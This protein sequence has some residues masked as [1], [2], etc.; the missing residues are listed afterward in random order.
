MLMQGRD[1]GRPR[2][3]KRIIPCRRVAGQRRACNR[4]RLQ[5][6]RQQCILDGR[7]QMAEFNFVLLGIVCRLTSFVTW[8]SEMLAGSLHGSEKKAP[9]HPQTPRGG[10][11]ARSRSFVKAC[12]GFVKAQLD[13][14]RLIWMSRLWNPMTFLIPALPMSRPWRFIPQRNTGVPRPRRL[15]ESQYGL[16]GGLRRG[17]GDYRVPPARST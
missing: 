6:H 2:K 15:R 9:P 7:Q 13:M 5:L 10:P 12:L 16:T 3:R 17:S 14:I 4:K 11:T 1:E 8:T